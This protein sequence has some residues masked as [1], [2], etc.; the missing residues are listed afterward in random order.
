M[1]TFK[2]KVLLISKNPGHLGDKAQGFQGLNL[3]S[4]A[5]YFAQIGCR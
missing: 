2:T 1:F 3:P 4:L 5:A